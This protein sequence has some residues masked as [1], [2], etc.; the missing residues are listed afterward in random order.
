[1]TIVNP[2]IYIVVAY[3][4]QNII[5][6]IIKKNISLKKFYYLKFL[7]FNL[8]IHNVNLNLKY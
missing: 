8:N 1:M 5:K 3:N 2:D 7:A 6:N 4:L